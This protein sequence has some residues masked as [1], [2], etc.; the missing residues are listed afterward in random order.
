MNTGTISSHLPPSSH[1]PLASI[2]NF[3]QFRQ[4]IGGKCTDLGDNSAKIYNFLKSRENK[5]PICCAKYCNVLQ[6]LS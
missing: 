4:N 1:L 6:M 2:W 3:P 5:S